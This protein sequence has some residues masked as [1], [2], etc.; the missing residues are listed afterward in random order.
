MKRALYLI[1]VWLFFTFWTFFLIGLGAEVF[2]ANDNWIDTLT[3]GGIVGALMT[4]L[5]AVFV[6]WAIQI[7]RAWFPRPMTGPLG[8]MVRAVNEAFAGMGGRT[9]P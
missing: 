9:K 1:A 2:R 8:E 5:T 7:H 4:L 3:A 6:C